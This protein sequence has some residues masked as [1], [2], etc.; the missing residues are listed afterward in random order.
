[1]LPR[2]GLTGLHGNTRRARLPHCVQNLRG[3]A[4]N[5]RLSSVCLQ[6]WCF[7]S[8]QFTLRVHNHQSHRPKALTN[9]CAAGP[10][11][12]LLPVLSLHPHPLFK[13]SPSRSSHAISNKKKNDPTSAPQSYSDLHQEIQASMPIERRAGH[14]QQL[15]SQKHNWQQHA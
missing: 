4:Q 10:S 7:C 14:S 12:P 1:M 13:R 15:S 9:L 2:S 3:R 11:T 6:H 5:N 8:H